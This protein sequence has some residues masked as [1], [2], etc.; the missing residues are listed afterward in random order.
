MLEVKNLT[1]VYKTKGGADVNALDGVT[2]RF[3]ETGMVFLL[4]KSGS[5]KSTLLNVCGGLD[6]PTS[7]EIIVKGRS[8]K[9][10]SQSDFDSYRNT[11]IG[12]I[13]Q[14]YNILNEF[15]VEDNI[16]LAL[17]LQGK[18]KDKKAIAELLEE[19]DLTGYAKRKPNTLSG[20][21]KQRIAI[22]RALVKQP[23]IIMADEP[24]GALDSATGKQVFDTLKKLSQTK[25]VVVVSHDRDFAEQ[26]GDRIIEL[27]DGKIISDITKTKEEQRAI[28]GNVT[29]VGD[30][31]C[32]KAGAK[33]TDKD[34][35]EIKA[36]LKEAKT[37]VVIA[38]GE[39]DVKAFKEVS[40]ITDDGKKEVFRDTD[41][42]K[43]AK[44][45][46]KPEDSRFIRS[47]LPMKHAMKIGVSGLKT[48]PFRLFFTIILCTVAFVMFG[49]LST[50]TFYDS[51]ATLKQTLKDSSTTV[52]KIGKEYQIQEQYYS[53]GELEH[54]YTGSR[55]T[56]FN[57]AD[58]TKYI[59]QFGDQVFGGVN[60]YSTSFSVQT[61]SDYYT[62]TINTIAYLPENNS[63]RSQI[64]TGNYPTADDEILISSYTANVMKECKVL[65]I[66]GNA[67]EVT[68][69][70][71]LIGKTINI[72]SAYK[73]AGIFESGAI[74]PKYDVLKSDDDP[75]AK[76]AVEEDFNFEL[77]DG[78]HLIAFVT[79]SK[80]ETVSSQF[81]GWYSDSNI[82]YNRY[83]LLANY[84]NN[85][86]GEYEFDPNEQW[87]N[88]GYAAFSDYKTDN[89]TFFTDGK[90]TVSNNEV[91]VS[92]YLFLN[93][94]Q[95]TLDLA[96][97]QARTAFDTAKENNSSY[98]QARQNI[99]NDFN[100]NASDNLKN[101]YI[102]ENLLY[103][104]WEYGNVEAESSPVYEYYQ[105][106]KT[107]LNAAN[108]DELLAE[109]KKYRRL[110]QNREALQSGNY[111]DEEAE[112]WLDLSNEQRKQYSTELM[113]GIKEIGIPSM[114]VKGR[115][116][117]NQDGMAYGEELVYNVVG[118]FGFDQKHDYTNNLLL[119]DEI[120]NALWADQSAQLDYYSVTTSKYQTPADAIYD[121]LYL[122]Y[123][124]SDTATETFAAIYADKAY[125]EDDS[126]IKLTSSLLSGFQMV[127]SMVE[128]MS[129]I[130]LYVGL[131]LA[132][133]SALLLSNFISVSISHKKRDIGILRAVG[134]RSLDVFKIFFSESFVI[135]F[136]CI[137]LSTIGSV[138]L[139]DVLNTQIAASIGASLFVFGIMSF[140]LLIGIALL[141]AIVATFLPVYNAAKKKP[142]ESIRA[143]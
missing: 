85:E 105:D 25:L 30:T 108:L 27:K 65:D 106:W 119:N 11:F 139:C 17:E 68:S 28:S 46:Y 136:I 32:L 10:F 41:E 61:R 33:L 55:D 142:V 111:Y 72:N 77:S 129:Q 133:F 49:L 95:S 67:I 80:L 35:E 91:V 34:F 59:E 54:T 19:V 100:T 23:E 53:M 127:D 3:P 48:K 29:A 101:N 141:T 18:P 15:S 117:N 114:T 71:Q 126:R 39:R 113:A 21:Q 96:H 112:A 2:M 38:S 125:D 120:A 64:T 135:A 103:N 86:T 7:G 37:D 93:R 123:D 130:F 6:S 42:G 63:L 66:N 104:E 36:F 58:I 97:Q 14:E 40:R 75:E 70:E 121:V 116:F 118:V 74:D 69:I 102:I 98:I 137:V 56:R 24:T 115:L 73:I 90:T 82:F 76:E 87:S 1:K 124:H 52:L 81:G 45:D 20:G 5:G 60:T 109:A 57:D 31:L 84:Y 43:L 9:H 83:I 122:P 8:S 140:L 110:A 128:N 131:V 4:G 143:L 79:K 12:F 50:M 44:K 132:V 138:I 89:V 99:I 13:F 51:S 78:T 26:Y 92:A 107:A 94:I 134:A 16:A 22:A 88:S 62:S 47:K